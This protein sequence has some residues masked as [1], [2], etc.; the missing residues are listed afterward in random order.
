[1]ATEGSCA[2]VVLKSMSLAPTP[3]PEWALASSM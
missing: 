2:A 1:M 3:T